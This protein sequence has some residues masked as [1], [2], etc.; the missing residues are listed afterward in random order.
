LAPDKIARQMDAADRSASKRTLLSASWG[1][2]MYRPQK[3]EFIPTPLWNDLTPVEW[4]IR[5]ISMNLHMQ[6][7]TWLVSRELTEAAGPWDTRMLVNNDGEYFCRVLLACDGVRFV[8]EA[9]VLYRMTGFNRVSYIGRSQPKMEALFLAMQLHIAYI[10]SLEDS[11]RVR[12]ACVQYLQ[13]WL[14]NFYPERPD[15]V[16]QAQQLAAAL[17]GRLEPPHLSWKYVWIQKSVGWPLAKRALM[18]TPRCKWSV[19]RAW[20]RALSRFESSD[21]GSSDKA[22]LASASR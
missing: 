16:K 13:D 14:I 5:K 12:A 20:D 2:F 17:G 4:L 21:R 19:I 11:A 6:T 18:L 15:L 1:R 10:R 7:A 22:E 8:P 9:R 3:A